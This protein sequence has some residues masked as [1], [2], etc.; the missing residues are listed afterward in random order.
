MNNN[1]DFQNKIK[2]K[3]S[4]AISPYEDYCYGFSNPGNSGENYI[5]TFHLGVGTSDFSL[6]H[7][8]SEV[9]AEID[10]FDKAEVDGTNIGQ[11][12]MIIVSSFCGPMGVIW[13]YDIAFHPQLRETNPFNISGIIN[14][15]NSEIPIYSIDPLIDATRRLFGTIDDPRFPIKPGAHV[16]CAGKNI[17]R[18]GPGHIYSA[19]GI[20]I[21]KNRENDACLLMEDMGLMNVD[22]NDNKSLYAYK[23]T[24][25]EKMA[26]SILKV[27][28]NQHVEYEEIFVGLTDLTMNYSEI[29][30]ALVAAPYITLAKNAIPKDTN[31][32]SRLNLDEWE[33][34]VI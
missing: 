16:P 26:K 4:G 33:D 12:N 13:G 18:K 21:S 24:I 6:V 27:G 14:A 3:L 7:P 22:S 5:L 11:I 15:D 17:K 25:V 30:C 20:G 32:L 34:I 1:E 31:D 2:I 19:I 10:A 9:L 28:E 8:G 29:G 23:Q